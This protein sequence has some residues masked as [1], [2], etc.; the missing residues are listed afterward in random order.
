M[1][2]SKKCLATALLLGTACIALSTA[3]VADDTATTSAASS[4]GQIETVVV[5]ALKRATD[6]QKTP[7][8]IT[9][10]TGEKL[11]AMGVTDTS[12]LARVSPGLVVTES[13]FSNSRITLRNIFASGEPTVGLY[14]DETPVTG[15]A[16]VNADAGG[17][18]PSIRLFDVDRV[19]VLR[20]PQGT[21]YGSSSMA[22]TVRLIFN[23]PDLDAFSGAASAEITSVE[24]GGVGYQYQGMLN[25]PLIDDKVGIRAVGFY[26]DAPGYVD[27]LYLHKNDINQQRAIGGRLM[28]RI[29]PVNG[30]TIDGLAVF[31]NTRGQMNDYFLADGA[32]KDHFEAQQPIRDEFQLYSGT[33]RWD[34]D[35][36][37]VTAVGSHE[38][39]DFTYGY[40]FSA[41]F[42]D[43][44]SL[45]P[46]GSP[47]Y[48]AFMDQA[49]SAAYSPQKTSVDTAE[50]RLNSNDSGPFVWTAGFFYSNRDG[51]IQ[52][53]IVR[54]SSTTGAILTPTGS[55][56]LGQ[57]VIEDALKQFA[58]YGEA[59][60][61]RR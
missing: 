45:Y 36:V 39:H 22:G 19:E 12:S 30:L 5:T 15:S 21:L 31:Q 20:G 43:F 18:M 32:Y 60:Y 44:G 28:L 48:D 50:L 38:V 11:Q 23:K 42:R 56:L 2:N 1:R 49:P 14:Y 33:V 54:A 52:S 37:T 26:Q 41:F 61:M 58:G 4:S 59:T 13:N 46:V 17:T 35:A 6:V 9:A 25:I 55:N 24:D 34:L 10:A 53:D 8:A 27:D 3:A 51:H 29:Q 47:T 7:L 16:G 40:D 57:R